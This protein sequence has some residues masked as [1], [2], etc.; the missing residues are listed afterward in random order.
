MVQIIETSAVKA[1]LADMLPWDRE[2]VLDE[3]RPIVEDD[4]LGEESW[5]DCEPWEAV[6]WFGADELLDSMEL[7]EVEDYYRKRPDE[8]QALKERLG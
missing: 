6:G 2:A 1:L 4:D 8:W 7:S 3:Y 5:K